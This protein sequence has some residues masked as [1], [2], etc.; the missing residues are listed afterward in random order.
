MYTIRA[1]RTRE[2]REEVVNACPGYMKHD[3]KGC[4]AITL[5]DSGLRFEVGPDGFQF[6][7]IFVE[8]IHGKTV[9]RVHT[10]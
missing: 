8:N 5:K 1:I 10:L 2:P 9:D 7:L 4:P 3:Y 6:D